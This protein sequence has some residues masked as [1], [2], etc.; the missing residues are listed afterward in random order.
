MQEK[1]F[2]SLFQPEDKLRW[3]F[4]S[5]QQELKDFLNRPNYGG[6]QLGFETVFFSLKPFFCHIKSL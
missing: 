1:K 4:F 3:I 6:E 2:V 5:F